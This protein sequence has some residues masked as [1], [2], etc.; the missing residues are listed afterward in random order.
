M[1]LEIKVIPN[2]KKPKVEEESG[3]LK[4]R[5]SAPPHEGKANRELIE[6]LSGHFKVRKNKIKIIRGE[7]SREKIVEITHE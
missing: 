2:A 5:L 6:I 1:R 7:K 3:K 4:I